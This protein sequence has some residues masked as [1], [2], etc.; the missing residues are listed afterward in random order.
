VLSY[1]ALHDSDLNEAKKTKPHVVV[2][3]PI[4]EA[5]RKA[6]AGILCFGKIKQIKIDPSIT[7]GKLPDNMDRRYADAVIMNGKT[8]YIIPKLSALGVAFTYF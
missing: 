6:Y 8:Q 7:S 5:T 3:N 1:S 2:L 4:P